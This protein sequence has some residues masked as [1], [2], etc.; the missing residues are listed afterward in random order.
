MA[1]N[2]QNLPPEAV[3]PGGTTAA[4]GAASA[5]ERPVPPVAQPEVAISP[6]E[7]APEVTIVEPRTRLVSFARTAGHYLGAAVRTYRSTRREGVSEQAKRMVRQHPSS[8]AG[9]AAAGYVVGRV[10]RGRV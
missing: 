9:A 6:A 3:T 1:T 2:E 7:A 5:F 4:G 8:L 10:L